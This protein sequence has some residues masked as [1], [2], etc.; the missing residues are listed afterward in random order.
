[1]PQVNE[2]I[3][4]A[5]IYYFRYK[6]RLTF[7]PRLQ[8]F[9]RQSELKFNRIS[10]NKVD[11]RV[12]T[13]SGSYS[14]PPAPPRYLH[15]APPSINTNNKPRTEGETARIQETNVRG[16]AGEGGGGTQRC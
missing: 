6:H 10:H 1:M 7:P 3:L 15:C 8:H 14:R 2:I 13:G 9:L 16:A 5:E 12:D 4:L 11:E